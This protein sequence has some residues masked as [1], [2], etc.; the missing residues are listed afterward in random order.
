MKKLFLLLLIS[1]SLVAQSPATGTATSITTKWI[2][3]P[4]ITG[5]TIS[6]YTATIIPPTGAAIAIPAC[7]TAISTNCIQ[8]GQNTASFVYTSAADLTYGIYSITIQTNAVN[9]VG[10]VLTATATNTAAY[11]AP[12]VIVVPAVGGVTIQFT[13]PTTN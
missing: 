2:P 13:I 11:A 4:E 6:G 8:P 12:P 10:T 3:V 5:V 7:V 9:S 1:T